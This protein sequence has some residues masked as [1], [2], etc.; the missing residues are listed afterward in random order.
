MAEQVPAAK[1]YVHQDFPLRLYHKTKP[2]KLVH[3]DA[4][5]AAALKQGYTT[6]G[7]LAP[8]DDNEPDAAP[9]AAPAKK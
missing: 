9:E 7:K 3:N 1:P 5:H 4:E 8:P 2:E 6:A